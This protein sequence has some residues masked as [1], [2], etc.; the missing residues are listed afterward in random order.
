MLTPVDIRTTLR[1][2][3]SIVR[4]FSLTLIVPAGVAL[5]YGESGSPFWWTMLIG[6]AIGLGLERLGPA[7]DIGLREG[8]LVVGLG[9]L[10]VAAVGGLPY[11][12][13]GG[14]ISS[15]MDAY[16]ESM[17]GF[18]TT[19]SSVI[20]D[21]SSHGHAI[22]FWRSMTQWLGGMGIIVLALAVLPRLSGGGRA[23]M[24]RES[25]GP[26]FDKLVPRIR[27]TAARLWGLY[28]GMTAIGVAAFWLSGAFGLEPRIGLYSAVCHAFAA[29]ATGGFSPEPRSF[30]AFGPTAQW[31]AIVLMASAGV[32]F[33][34][35]YR[36]LFRS[37]RAFLR[38]EEL[39]SYLALVAT[40]A[41]VFATILILEDRYSAPNAIRHAVFQAVS[42]ITTTGYASTDFAVW[43]APALLL[44]LLLMFPG[45]CSGSTGGAIKIVRA[46]L[47]IRVM[48]REVRGAAHP[49]LLQP[50]RM[51]GRAVDEKAVR[52]V[53]G[54]ILLYI[55]VF[56]VGAILLASDAAARGLPVTVEEA[57]A[58]S[59][60]ALGNVGPGFGAS[61]PMGS[62]AEYGTPGKLVMIGLMWTGRLELLPALVLVSR[63]FW[64]R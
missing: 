24:E 17:S 6:S 60:T 56:I 44:L 62:F 64:L 23:L 28:V 52:A 18:T 27:D 51:G 39:R 13:E 3:G 16:F 61:G 7:H 5:I 58:A 40:A 20:A 22:L 59:A 12:F 34:L 15:P 26:D 41:A 37:K 50:I 1:T 43:S 55:V 30:E 54:F 29:L 47:A 11:V 35:W 14:D 25:P 36:G 31:I 57:L 63:S 49:E 45:G 19:G 33:G 46:R 10:S 4:W 2:I 48:R 38:D 42:T 9:W 32:N 8:F 21:L 53:V